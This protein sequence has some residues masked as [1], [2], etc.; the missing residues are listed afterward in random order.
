MVSA[1]H[2]GGGLEE[3]SVKADPDQGRCF[4]LSDCPQ[5]FLRHKLAV[6]MCSALEACLHQGKQVW[7]S[8]IMFLCD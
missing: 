5:G 4:D 7:V 1:R 6:D 8:K 3:C 2:I